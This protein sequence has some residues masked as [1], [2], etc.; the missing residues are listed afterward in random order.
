VWER[1]TFPAPSNPAESDASIA[2]RVS[3]V[4]VVAVA[5]I[6]IVAKRTFGNPS[7]K[8][9]ISELYTSQGLDAR[10]A[11]PSQGGY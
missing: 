3:I 11:R 9:N 4:I 10:D 1:L 5:F 8:D 6:I 2:A 7:E